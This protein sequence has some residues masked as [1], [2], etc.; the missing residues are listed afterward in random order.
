VD[1]SRRVEKLIADLRAFSRGLP[2]FEPIVITSLGPYRGSDARDTHH[3]IAPGLNEL[4][5]DRVV[6]LAP[7]TLG[8][9]EGT[10][11]RNPG[12]PLWRYVYRDAPVVKI[13]YT[14]RGFERD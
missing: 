2:A 11:W 9:A 5:P 1:H 14:G 13:H 7:E 10:S 3:F 8:I 6:L 4:L 12:H